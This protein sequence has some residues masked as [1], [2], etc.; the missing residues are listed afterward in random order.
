MPGSAKKLLLGKCRPYMQLQGC[1]QPWNWFSTECQCEGGEGFTTI[2]QN[3]T[4]LPLTLLLCFDSIRLV[5]RSIQTEV[6]S[7]EFSAVPKRISV[8]RRGS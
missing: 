3:R 8:P 2:V 5:P 6:K 7:M 4:H 1:L